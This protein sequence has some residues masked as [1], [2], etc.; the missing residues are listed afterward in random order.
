MKMTR[1][2]AEDYDRVIARTVEPLRTAMIAGQKMGVLLPV[3]G[4]HRTTYYLQLAAG[5]GQELRW[6]GE[7]ATVVAKR[8]QDSLL[9]AQ[10]VRATGQDLAAIPRYILPNFDRRPSP[11]SLLPLTGILL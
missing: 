9:L 4:S 1:M 10:D 6:V 2:R 7:P 11:S 3:G 8:W 5:V